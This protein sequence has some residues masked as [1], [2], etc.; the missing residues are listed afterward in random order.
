[1][2]S[3]T[4][5]AQF[6]LVCQFVLVFCETNFP[7]FVCDVGLKKK[8]SVRLRESVLFSGEVFYAEAVKNGFYRTPSSSRKLTLLSTIVFSVKN[9]NKNINE[10]SITL[11]LFV[12]YISVNIC[13]NI[14]LFGSSFRKRL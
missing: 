3:I 6:V 12:H 10:E 2:S 8:I 13:K 1:M 7:L 14:P 11:K 4:K 9:K 5:R